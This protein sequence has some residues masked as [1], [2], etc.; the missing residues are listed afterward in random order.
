MIVLPGD[1]K[2]QYY[3]RIEG[4][5]NPIEYAYIPKAGD[6]VIGKVIAEKKNVAYIIDI[7]SYYALSAMVRSTNTE[8][9][10]GDFVLG[11]ISQNAENMEDIR[12]I[13]NIVL[14]RVPPSKLSRI[15]GT[16]GQMIKLIAELSGSK[17]GVGRN[18]VVWIEGGNLSKAIS[19]VN[20]IIKRAHLRDVMEY[21]KIKY[22]VKDES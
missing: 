17:L 12:V 3:L 1:R 5:D 6:I 15:V 7:F 19:I 21:I 13:K 10:V 8:L 16:K 4:I 14:Y 22:G 9:K 2:D 11:T 20:D 18:G